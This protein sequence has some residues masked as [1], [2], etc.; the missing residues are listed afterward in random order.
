MFVQYYVKYYMNM[1]H[2]N[3]NLANIYKCVLYS[4][5]LV[6]RSLIFVT[7]YIYKFALYFCEYFL[8]CSF[9]LYINMFYVII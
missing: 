3:Y 5:I 4:I 8:R 6:T 7:C 2:V 9:I 1:F